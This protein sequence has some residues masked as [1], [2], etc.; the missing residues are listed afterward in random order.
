M[1]QLLSQQYSDIQKK[2]QV[3]LQDEPSANKLESLA[4]ALLGRLLEIDISVAKSGFQHGGDAGAAGRQGRRFRIEAKKYLETTSLSSRELLGEIDHAISRD[5]AL[6]AWIL[7]ATR[8]VSEQLYQDLVKKGENI[9]VP[10]VIFDWKPSGLSNL[11][12]LCAE[13]ADL[14]SSIFSFE[15]GELAR[16]L[17]EVSREVTSEIRRDLQVWNLGFETLRRSSHEKIKNVW[18]SPKVSH[19]ELGQNAAGG[20][21]AKK[22]KRRGPHAALDAWFAGPALNDAPAA[23]VG[24]D[25]TGKT[26]ATLDWLIEDIQRHPIILVIPSPVAAMG[27][28]AVSETRVKVFLAERL[29][30]LGGQ[31]NVEHWLRRLERLLIRPPEDGPVF[32]VV[33][34]GLNQESSLPWLNILKVFKEAHFLVEYAS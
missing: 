4:A 16:Q 34:D 20:A 24:P 22:I 25:G 18:K 30:E 8:S 10:V 9:G 17:S 6:E 1:T 31:R 29:Y 23:I 2:L 33:F 32:T 11:A 28:Q 7:V 19:S 5:P 3:A 27:L 15:A 12:A 14:V 21:E 13:N 26:W